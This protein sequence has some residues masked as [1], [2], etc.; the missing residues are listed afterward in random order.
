VRSPGHAPSS[1][2]RE[3][4]GLLVFILIAFGVPWACWFLLAETMAVSAMF[5]SFA[6]Y[7][8][9]AA[10]SA[11]GFAAAFAEGG[12][13][14]LRKFSARV[15]GLRF[16]LWIWIAA[17]LLPFLAAI[18]TFVNHPGDLFQGGV[19]RWTSLVATV[20]FANLFTGPIAEE[21][22]WRG[23]LL[24]FFARRW[25]PVTA[26]LIIAP[27]WAAWH[28]PIYY[29]S[30]FAH[31]RSAL[32]FLVWITAWSVVLALVVTRARG[33]VLPS[34][35]A[36]WSMNAQPAIFF[37]LLPTLA[38][39]KQPGGIAYPLASAAVAIVVY[40]AWRGAKWPADES[41]ARMQPTI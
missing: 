37:A 13:H 34:M 10:C 36:H 41:G 27:I 23:Y 19:P 25:R 21:F 32:G 15:V 22:G 12:W 1:E 18:L 28:I 4:L 9:T 33:S 16:P 40:I 11:A 29:D 35:L 14:G 39:E 17:L 38:G 30:V 3:R 2:P 6:T 20:S 31:V 8:F 5:N 24:G 26:G 7:G